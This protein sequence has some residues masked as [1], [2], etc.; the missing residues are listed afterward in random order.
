MADVG[1]IVDPSASPSPQQTQAPQQAQQQTGQII[2]PTDSGSGHIVD[3]TPA[4]KST[5][6]GYWFPKNAT[7]QVQDNAKGEQ[8]STHNVLDTTAHLSSD[9]PAP[10]NPL[11]DQAQPIAEHLQNSILQ[12]AINKTG[13]KIIDWDKLASAVGSKAQGALVGAE[14]ALWKGGAHS[15]ENVTQFLDAAGRGGL[16]VAND[17]TGAMVADQKTMPKGGSYDEQLMRRPAMDTAGSVIK[18]VGDYVWNSPKNLNRVMASVNDPRQMQILTDTLEHH[19][20]TLTG[21]PDPNRF[22]KVAKIITDTVVQGGVNPT[23]YFPVSDAWKFISGMSKLAVDTKVGAAVIDAMGHAA[24]MPELTLAAKQ[25]H[26]VMADALSKTKDSLDFFHRIRPDL[27]EHWADKGKMVVMGIQN[28]A[29]HVS[30]EDE[31]RHNDLLDRL[32][33]VMDKLNM[34]DAPP[35]EVQ[36]EVIR[37]MY[38]LGTEADAKAAQRLGNLWGW[39]PDDAAKAARAQGLMDFNGTVN[40]K[41]MTFVAQ[42]GDGPTVQRALAW[43]KNNK[44]AIDMTDVYKNEGQVTSSIENMTAKDLAK[45]HNLSMTDLMKNRFQLVRSMSRRALIAKQLASAV[46]EDPS[47][48]KITPDALQSS[49]EEGAKIAGEGGEEAAQGPNEWGQDQLRQWMQKN[50]EDRQPSFQVGGKFQWGDKQVRLQDALTKV[51]RLWKS[52]LLGNI[53]P[54]GLR[55]VGVVTLLR[56]GVKVAAN[57]LRMAVQGIPQATQ[58]EMKAS[59]AWT[60][61]WRETPEMYKNLMLRTGLGAG[62]GAASGAMKPTGPNDP[63]GHLRQMGEG[64]VLGGAFGAAMP[65]M[66]RLMDRFENA[67]RASYFQDLKKSLNPQSAADLFAIGAKVANDLGGYQH[68]SEFVKILQGIG[69][70]FI[71]YRGNTVPRAFVHGLVNKTGL[72]TNALNAEQNASGLLPANSSTHNPVD[73]HQHERVL[74]AIDEAPRML[75]MGPFMGSAASVGPAVQSVGKMLF[76]K[77]HKPVGIKEM[78]YDALNM[79]EGGSAAQTLSPWIDPYPNKSGMPLWA[80]EINRAFGG[81]VDAPSYTAEKIGTHQFEKAKHQ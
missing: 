73:F 19:F 18:A 9:K 24:Q 39:R 32:S 25:M 63:L 4:S 56:G 52:S 49:V 22:P 10:H 65:K 35:R 13:N 27:D 17:I 36:H 29:D 6:A 14:E 80:Q 45:S 23:S 38:T 44:G 77:E 70:T 26:G 76:D 8:Q 48:M 46:T 21:L 30:F 1:T 59:G 66:G 75:N 69:G 7:K 11:R 20:S 64:A 72:V 57:G 51:S 42:P 47:L 81:Y 60:E 15:V 55:N 68:T 50:V 61:F 71:A 31:K 2:D 5:I 53:L 54:H 74:G 34:W 16:Q 62:I 67:Y 78:G 33:P 28:A 12:M 40:P 37:E 3:P 43:W 41:F 79:V 58:A